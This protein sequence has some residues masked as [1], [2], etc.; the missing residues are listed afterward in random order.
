[1]SEEPCPSSSGLI[2]ILGVLLFNTQ[3]PQKYPFIW[4]VPT[5]ASL[6]TLDLIGSPQPLW[7]A[8]IGQISCPSDIHVVA[9]MFFSQI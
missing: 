1:M 7:G 3:Y 8:K 6:A 2:Q 9:H 5:I 4:G